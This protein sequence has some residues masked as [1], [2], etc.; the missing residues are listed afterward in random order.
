MQ[1]GITLRMHIVGFELGYAPQASRAKAANYER[2]ATARLL[3]TRV[4]AGIAASSSQQ[5]QQQPGAGNA[6]VK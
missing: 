5:Q 3:S 4:L 2:R 1:L 6:S